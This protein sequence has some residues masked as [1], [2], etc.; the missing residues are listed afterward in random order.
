MEDHSVLNISYTGYISRQ[1]M[2]E[3]TE[4]STILQK[5]SSPLD[6]I[7]IIPYGTTT[8]R[9]NTGDISTVSSKVIAEQPVAN[10]LAA[11]E[12]RVPGLI[13]TQSNGLPG[14]GFSVEMSHY[15]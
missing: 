6:A 3:G 2:W 1:V 7:V 10:P 5:S 12:G 11:L 9:L 14:A 4:T 15:I 8:A 13:I